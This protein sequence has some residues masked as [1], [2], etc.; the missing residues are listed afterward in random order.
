MKNRGLLKLP[1]ELLLRVQSTSEGSDSLPKSFVING[2]SKG[3]E[4]LKNLQGC[5]Y[6]HSRPDAKPDS[7]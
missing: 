7:G 6:E 1:D 2:P 4:S 3:L 5:T